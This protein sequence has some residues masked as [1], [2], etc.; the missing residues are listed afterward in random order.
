MSF[1]YKEVKVKEKTKNY[2]VG[3]VSTEG[4]SVSYGRAISAYDNQTH[5]KVVTI[6]ASLAKDLFGSA[7]GAVGRGFELGN[8]VFTIIG[9]FQLALKKRCFQKVPQKYCFLAK[10]ISIFLEM[11]RIQVPWY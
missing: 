6:D 10:P 4:D 8:Q 1:I 9:V 3:V 7:R 11:N 5:N 2:R